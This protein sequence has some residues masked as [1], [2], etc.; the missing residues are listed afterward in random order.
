VNQIDIIRTEINKHINENPFEKGI[1]ENF[2]SPSKKFRIEA[3]NLTFKESNYDLTK[4]E[5]FNTIK[6][7]KIFEFYV[8]DSNFF[9]SFLSV[10]NIDYLICSED[11]YG[12]QT[13]ID[14]T[15]QIM[16]SYSPNEDGFIWTDFYLSPNGKKL[17]TIG[18]YW[19]CPYVIKLFDFT[20]PMNLPL[21]EIKE[22][23]LLD[24]DEIIVG[25]LDNET[26]QMKGYKREREPEY[27]DG[28]SF[29]M[30]IINETKVE[31]ELKINS[32]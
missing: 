6:T 3:T 5:I 29:R 28:G 30:K 9:H 15:N 27:F 7:Q 23:D 31:R 22:I 11:I 12:G 20:E 1:L 24:N 2:I 14:L 4:I 26:L 10:N 19:A 18:C 16:K 13:V 25:W 17:A 32:T 21:N 8:N